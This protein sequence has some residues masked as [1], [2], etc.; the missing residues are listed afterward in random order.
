MKSLFLI[1]IL[2]LAAAGVLEFAR[3]LRAAGRDLDND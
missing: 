1:L 2:I 3:E